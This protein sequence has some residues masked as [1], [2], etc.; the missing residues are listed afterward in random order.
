MARDLDG[1]DDGKLDLV[2][3]IDCVMLLLLFFILTTRF[4]PDELQVSALLPTNTGNKSKQQHD[5]VKPPQVIHLVVTPIDMPRG[6]QPSEYER[7]WQERHEKRAVIRVG[8][9]ESLELDY[10]LTHAANVAGDEQQLNNLHQYV[11]EGLSAYELEGSRDI[12]PPIVI[13]CFSGLPWRH[14]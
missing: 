4:T 11:A 6:L 8:G 3:M 13:H 9:A 1:V 2:P 14:A 10:H 7:R 5:V 12:Q